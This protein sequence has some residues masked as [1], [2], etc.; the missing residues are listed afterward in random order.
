MN[1]PCLDP[2]TSCWAIDDVKEE[3]SPCSWRLIDNNQGPSGR[4][5][6]AQAVCDDRYL[7]VFGG[8]AGVAM[9]EKVLNDLWMLDCSGEPGTEVW[10]PILP[11]AEKGDGL[12]E[13]RSYHRMVCIGTNLYVFGGC[14]EQ[15]GRLS[16]LWKFDT[17]HKTWHC[18]ARS[19]HRHCK[20]SKGFSPS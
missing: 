13:A 10:S 8:R 20:R 17:V 11:D 6:H 9:D 5:A 18:L 2:K 7:Y 1:R 3:Q 4:L 14:G 15:H 12:P 16:D 19:I